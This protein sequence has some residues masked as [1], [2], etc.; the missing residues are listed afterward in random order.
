MPE[1]KIQRAIAIA[2][3]IPKSTLLSIGSYPTKKR[4][5]LSKQLG[6]VLRLPITVYASVLECHT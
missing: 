3:I 5:G 1:R 4:D 6:E 2:F